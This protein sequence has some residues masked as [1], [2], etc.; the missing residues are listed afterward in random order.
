MGQKTG[1]QNRLHIQAP[2]L[3]ETLQTTE[4]YKGGSSE[5]STNKAFKYQWYS[6][7]IHPY[8]TF[9]TSSL[10]YEM[11]FRYT[12]KP[13]QLPRRTPLLQRHTLKRPLSPLDRKGRVWSQTAGRKGRLALLL[14]VPGESISHGQLVL[15]NSA[16]WVKRFHCADLDAQ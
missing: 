15:P 11:C 4:G 2:A 8:A 10:D 1:L 6:K 7:L 16:S 9:P 12:A 5:T 3:Q 14:Q 13:F